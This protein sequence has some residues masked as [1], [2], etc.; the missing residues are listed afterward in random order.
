M[1]CLLNRLEACN[2]ASHHRYSITNDM[3]LDIQWWL[4]FL[5][6]FNRVSLIKPFLWDFQCFNFATD[7]SLCGGGATCRSDCIRF[8]FPDDILS[9][10]LHINT[11]ELSTIVV[12][13][14]H[15]A[16]QLQGSKFIIS[17]DNSTAVAVIN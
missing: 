7:A 5:P 14:K 13:V 6:Q 4:H 9:S 12:A 17:S 3:Q 10:S 1:A 11:L 8:I 15:W 16:L 2:A